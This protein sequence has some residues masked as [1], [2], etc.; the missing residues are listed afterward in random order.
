[1]FTL[2]SGMHIKIQHKYEFLSA[3]DCFFVNW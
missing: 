3:Y 1:M 2:V